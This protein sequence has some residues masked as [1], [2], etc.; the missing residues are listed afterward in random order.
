MGLS[1]TV[2]EIYG[3]FS[4][5]SRKK[6]PFCFASRWKGSNF[7]LE[8]GTGAGVQNTTM[9]ELPGGQRSLTI[10]SAFWIK[11]MN[12]T[13][14]QTDTPS[15]GRTDTGPPRRAVKIQDKLTLWSISLTKFCIYKSVPVC[16]TVTTTTTTTVA[17]TT[18]TETTT[19][20]EVTT[21]SNAVSAIGTGGYWLLSS[22]RYFS[23]GFGWT[24]I[25]SLMFTL[26]VNCT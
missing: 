23:A 6:L 3:D 17:T 10:S 21:T 12:V 15:D 24:V 25:T 19:T 2:S 14:R 5:K 26:S 16:V 4:R 7:Q 13:D 9:I 1:R 22:N 20:T 8:L 11:C 18:V